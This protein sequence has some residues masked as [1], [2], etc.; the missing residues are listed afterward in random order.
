MPTENFRRECEKASLLYGNAVPP[1]R[2]T[3]M[4]HLSKLRR[5]TTAAPEQTMD[6]D[7]G[8]HTH[9]RRT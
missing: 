4:P 5:R 1:A 6:A 9:S 8:D 7:D 3:L 2:G